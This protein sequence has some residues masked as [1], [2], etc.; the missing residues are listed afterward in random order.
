VG[1]EVVLV[2]CT[3]VYASANGGAVVVIVGA[4]QGLE[5]SDPPA[6]GVGTTRISRAGGSVGP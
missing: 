2:C 4:R 3:P 6:P 5:Q 1:H